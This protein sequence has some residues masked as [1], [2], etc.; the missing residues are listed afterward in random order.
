M[1]PDCAREALELSELGQRVAGLPE[2]PRD[3]LTV[4]RSRQAL[5]AAMNES[6]LTTDKPRSP[7]RRAL[8]AGSSAVAVAAAAWFLIARARLSPD[9]AAAAVADS[10]S[11]V[12]VRSGPGARW[13]ERVDTTL[14]SVSLADGAAAFVVHPH[15][16]RRVIIELPDGELEDMGTVFELRV[17]HEHTQH[18]AVTEGTV[19]VRF[20]GKAEFRLTA[21]QAWE[22]S[23]I[24]PTA[25]RGTDEATAN[26]AGTPPAIAPRVAAKLALAKREEPSAKLA[27]PGASAASSTKAEDD[28]YLAIVGLLRGAHYAD[29]RAAAK[30]YLLQFPNGFRRVEVLNIATRAAGADAGDAQ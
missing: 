9:H 1:C 17:D 25:Q 4:R 15:P 24:S 6:L 5:L 18:I 22:A 23:P 29:A 11:I 20:R 7:R 12:V 3:P 28:A 27:P 14:D 8:I 19:A 10:K 26:D 13:S 2:A 16:G 30:R 21:G